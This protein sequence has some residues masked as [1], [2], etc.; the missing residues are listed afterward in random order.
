MVAM[1]THMY[2]SRKTGKNY[3]IY[4]Y[5]H[6]AHNIRKKQGKKGK[7]HMTTKTKKNKKTPPNVRC[8]FMLAVTLFIILFTLFSLVSYFSQVFFAAP[9]TTRPP[10]ESSITYPEDE[11]AQNTP[12]QRANLPPTDPTPEPIAIPTPANMQ[13]VT[14]DASPH[15]TIAATA[16]PTE[17]PMENPTE[18]PTSE[19]TFPDLFP[20]PTPTPEI[21]ENMIVLPTPAQTDAPEEIMTTQPSG[22]QVGL[23]L[24]AVVS[25][26][27]FIVS[28]LLFVIKR[29]KSQRT[30]PY[31][32][33]LLI[34]TGV[35]V[36][37]VI[38]FVFTT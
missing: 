16:E 23:S 8:I 37:S 30:R 17:N 1:A 33:A 34:S 29:I 15:P 20:T 6:E 27:S 31:L 32:I 28:I 7:T 18:N 22:L 5:K 35:F 2:I 3:D 36:F 24:L 10:I 14:V 25:L 38:A 13:N 12:N 11:P 4:L 21:E 26:V 9:T 19:N